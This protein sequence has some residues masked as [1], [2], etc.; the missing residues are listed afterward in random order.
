[1]DAR[2]PEEAIE[3]I[4]DGDAITQVVYNLLDNAVKFARPGS[5]LS[6]SL[7]KT[8]TQG[9]CIRSE[10]RETIPEAELPHLFDRSIRPTAAEAVTGTAWDWG[11]I[12]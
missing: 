12:S 8:G 1:M 10:Y 2:V 11:C 4:G 9:L 5:L 7:W 3:V 6:L